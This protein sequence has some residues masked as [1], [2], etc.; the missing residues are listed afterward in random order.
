MGKRSKSRPRYPT[1]LSD[2]KW[3]EVQGLILAQKR[4]GRPREV[5]LRRVLDALFFITRA[6]CAWRLLPK[7]NFPPWETI[8]GY[9]RQWSKAGVWQRRH[10]TLRARV[11][12]KKGRYKHP[13]A[14]SIDRQSVKTTASSGIKGFDAGKKI[15]GR[16]R[17]ILVDTLGLLMAV[18]VT[19]ASVQDRDGAK[20]WLRS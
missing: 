1:D 18:I 7:K 2:G 13:T 3:R 20:R 15:Q 8:Y 5:S 6:G 16:K 17:P 14:G 12:Q 10:D 9:F 11:R 19:A 4:L